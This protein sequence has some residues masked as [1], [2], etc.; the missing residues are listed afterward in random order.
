MWWFSEN[1]EVV[2]PKKYH[3]SNVEQHELLPVKFLW[4]G[5]LLRT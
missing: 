4:I 2:S 5:Y 1:I 3:R